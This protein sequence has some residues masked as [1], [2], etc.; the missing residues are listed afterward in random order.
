[1]T[2]SSGLGYTRTDT[3]A[4]ASRHT[5]KTYITAD[6]LLSRS[7]ELGMQ[8]LDSGYHPDIVVGVWR[9]GTPVAIA[10]HELL[11]IAGHRADHIPIRTQFYR[12]NILVLVFQNDIR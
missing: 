4:A 11:D 5:L 10:I 1:M 3:I 6:Q 2:A 7:Y 8:V 9:G 12:N